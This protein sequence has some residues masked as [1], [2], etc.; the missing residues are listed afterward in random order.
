M[1]DLDSIIRRFR[2]RS[3][4]AARQLADELEAELRNAEPD[5][6][7]VRYTCSDGEQVRHLY[8]H[9]PYWE[10]RHNHPD[11]TATPFVAVALPQGGDDEA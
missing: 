3:E 1:L 11:A 5:G 9:A 10:L 4:P 7:I 8:S 2:S 6:W